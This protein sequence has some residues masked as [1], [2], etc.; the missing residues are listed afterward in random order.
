MCFMVTQERADEVGHLSA[1]LR[2]WAKERTDVV[3]IVLVGSWARGDAR[4]DSDV[5]VVL[6]TENQKPYLEGDA[7]LHELGGVRLVKTRQ[8]GPLTERRFALSSGLEVELGVAP[9]SWG[10]RQPGRWGYAPSCRGRRRGR[11][12]PRGATRPAGCRLQPVTRRLRR[13]KSR[14]PRNP[15]ERSSEN[16]SST[17]PSGA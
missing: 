6:L 13:V 5:D 7:W 10:L 2:E 17:H 1:A 9:T 16:S 11:P 3:A 8:W 14:L 15:S 4:M 12:R